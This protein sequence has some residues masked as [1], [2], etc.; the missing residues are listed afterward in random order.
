MKHLQI[1]LR[2]I[3][4]RAIEAWRKSFRSTP[5]VSISQGD[6]FGVTADAIVSPAN[7]FGYMDGGIDLVYSQFFGWEVEERLRSI[8]LEKYDGEIPVGQAEIVPT[9]HNSI[10]LLISAPTMRVPMN[11]SNTAHAYLAFR[12]AL[13]AVRD[14]NQKVERQERDLEAEHQRQA[15]SSSATHASS[16]TVQRLPFSGQKIQKILCPGLCTGE[17]R[18]SFERSAKQMRAAYDNIVAQ[19]LETKGG[20]AQA[21]RNH[22]HLVQDGD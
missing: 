15:T 21:V 19:Q 14:W 5:Q 3:N 1:H 16:K 13:R 4:L 7:S 11:V 12:A 6:I 18:M 2:A 20:L 8:I 22:L 10:P 17:G 9:S